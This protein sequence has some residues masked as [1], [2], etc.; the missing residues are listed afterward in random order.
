MN[1][2]ERVIYLDFRIELYCGIDVNLCMVL[3]HQVKGQR[4]LGENRQQ[5][6]F[7]LQ[8]PQVQI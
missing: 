1:L 4:A 2:S 8:Q 7:I 6:G 5:T 3:S